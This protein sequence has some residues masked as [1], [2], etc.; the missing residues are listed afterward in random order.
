MWRDELKALRESRDKRLNENEQKQ[1]KLREERE[2]IHN[3]FNEARDKIIM[4][5]K[6][7][8]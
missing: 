5:H 2:K 7:E 4:A 1:I 3:E 6:G 8:A